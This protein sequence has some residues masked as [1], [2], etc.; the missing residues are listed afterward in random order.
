MISLWKQ[1]LNNSCMPSNEVQS[2]NKELKGFLVKAWIIEVQRGE[3][4]DQVLHMLNRPPSILKSSSIPSLGNDPKSSH[5]PKKGIHPNKFEL[6]M[7]KLKIYWANE[8]RVDQLI[9]TSQT[10][11]SVIWIES[12]VDILIFCLSLLT[13]LITTSYSRPLL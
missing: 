2:S 5:M 13:F 7:Q 10:H 9:T 8:R 11:N 3:E 4:I 12:F 1:L 6:P